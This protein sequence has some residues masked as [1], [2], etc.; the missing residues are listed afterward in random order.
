[1]TAVGLEP[2][3]LRNGALGNRLAPLGQTVLSLLKENPEFGIR[4]STYSICKE[5]PHWGLSP[6]PSVYKTDALPLSY[7]G[8]PH[9]LDDCLPVG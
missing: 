4:G 1:M 3:P 7:E 6:G 5:G 9:D 2:T 8:G